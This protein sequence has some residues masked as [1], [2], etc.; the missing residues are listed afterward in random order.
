MSVQI[1]PY[2]TD[3]HGIVTLT[4]TQPGR[5][6]VVLD[7]DLLK[8][9]AATLD[10]IAQLPDLK[11]FIL[12]SD[13]RVFVAGANLEE[14][15]GLSDDDLHA[16]L[17]FGAEAFIRI[18]RLPCTSVAA[19]HG[20]ALGGGLEIA[21]HCDKLVAAPPANPDKPY[22]VGLPEA[23]LGL[24][25]GWGGTAMLAA[26]ID[27]VE[28]LKQV[29]TGRTMPFDQARSLSLFDAIAGSRDA[30][31]DLARTHAA[32][33]KLSARE[34]PRFVGDDDVVPHVR[35]AKNIAHADIP[36]TPAA[37]AVLECTDA[38]LTQGWEACLE[39]ERANLVR[40]RHTEQ[41]RAALEKFFAKA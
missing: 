3:D 35:A 37:Q 2:N 25:P 5:P 41:A 28:A 13:S 4:L 23:G 16:Y 6:V 31:L 11:G 27:P 36:D 21:L 14:I 1:L 19:I 9:I 40:L 38:A 32:A 39:A 24:C 17:R 18:T 22:Q 26:R 29:T 10:E 7:G 33:P 8:S 20:A 34:Y 12:A 30:L 15:S